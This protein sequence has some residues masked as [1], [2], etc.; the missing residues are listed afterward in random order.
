MYDKF[1]LGKFFW[2]CYCSNVFHLVFMSSSEEVIDSILSA[3]SLYDVLGVAPTEISQDADFVRRKYKQVALRVHPDKCSDE[4]SEQAF[5]KVHRA[6][7]V[8]SDQALR[9]VYDKYGDEADGQ[10]SII[11]QAKAMFPGMK[12][13]VAIEILGMILGHSG[14][15]PTPHGRSMMTL[16]EIE[17]I[18]KCSIHVEKKRKNFV[19]ISIFLVIFY[20]TFIY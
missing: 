16:E 17:E 2:E 11:E 1:I 6:Y 20:L 13:D 8:L 10:G 3:A 9:D 7:T 19:S 5:K 18:I 4:R 12:L 15:K 14:G